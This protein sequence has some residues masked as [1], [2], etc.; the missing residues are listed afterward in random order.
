MGDL[1]KN[2]INIKERKLEH[3]RIILKEDVS[4]HVST[5]FEYVH[6]IHNSLPE[7]SLDKIDMTT[8][9]LGRRFSYPILIDSMTGGVRGTE[10]INRAL[11]ELAAE[12]KIPISCGSEK[13]AIKDPSVRHTYRVIRDV[14]SDIYLIGNIGAHDLKEDP[15]RIAE[16]AVSIIDAD[17]L[18]IHLNPLQEAIQ[19]GSVDYENVIRVIEK[20]VDYLDVPVIVK[21]TGAGISF[22]VAKILESI[23]VSAINIAGVGGTSW[24]AV[25]A[26]R[27][28]S[29]G[30]K[31]YASVGETFWDWGIPTAA[32]LIEVVNSTDIPIIAS[33]GIRN[34]LDILKSLVLGANLVGMAAPF[35]KA[36]YEGEDGLRFFIEK[37]ILEL[38]IGML[39]VGSPS[40]S[41]LNEVQYVLLSPLKDWAIQRGVL[42]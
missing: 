37:V 3:I 20:T 8:D 42:K 33:G 23:G 29:G 10:K 34:G 9:F 17:A 36:L 27:H 32:S 35:L 16:E 13:A 30:N 19:T 4:H 6:L 2:D 38:K 1:F 28:L 39:L 31:L 22:G 15:K 40:V 7:L 18:A 24:S 26:K 12:Y 25:E 14:S 11:A 5:W 21:E 41:A